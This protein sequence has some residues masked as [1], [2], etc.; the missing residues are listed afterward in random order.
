MLVLPEM[1]AG[2]LAPKDLHEP[3]LS[4]IDRE[5]EP[6]V[7][8]IGKEAARRAGLTETEIKDLYADD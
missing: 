8:N 6:H 1:T 5:A 7:R 3:I 2:G 4:G